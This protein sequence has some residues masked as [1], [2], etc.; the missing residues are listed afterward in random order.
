MGLRRFLLKHFRPRR[1]YSHRD[2]AHLWWRSLGDRRKERV[3][4]LPADEVERWW[5]ELSDDRQVVFHHANRRF[6]EL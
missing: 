4:G 6:Y 3:T 5:R 1:Y 2:A